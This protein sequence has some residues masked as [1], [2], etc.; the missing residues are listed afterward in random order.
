MYVSV[1]VGVGVCVHGSGRERGSRDVY[2]H[3]QLG[4]TIMQ[5]GVLCVYVHDS[6]NKT[7]HVHQ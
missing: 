4:Y 3:M 5:K 1:C 6:R 7:I 2:A